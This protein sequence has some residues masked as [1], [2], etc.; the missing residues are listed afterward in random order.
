V[1]LKPKFTKL[2]V[3]FL[4]NESARTAPSMFGCKAEVA[5]VA[6]CSTT[7]LHEEAVTFL[8]VV[9]AVRAAVEA[10]TLLQWWKQWW[11]F[12][13]V[14][15][16]VTLLH[17]VVEAATLLHVALRL[18]KRVTLPHVVALRWVDAVHLNPNFH[19]HLSQY[20]QLHLKRQAA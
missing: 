6:L 16:A 14:V 13:H 7:F 3:K 9:E 4:F 2:L 12:L 5:R 17:V 10:V 18:V 19:L 15:E 8:R 11:T 1:G 20:L